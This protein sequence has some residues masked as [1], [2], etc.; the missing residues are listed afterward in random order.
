MVNGDRRLAK[1]NATD[2]NNNNNTNK[3]KIKVKKNKVKT[4]SKSN[5]QRGID[6]TKQ[7]INNKK[8]KVRKRVKKNTDITPKVAKI[9]KLMLVSIVHYLTMHIDQLTAQHI[10]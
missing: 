6:N 7:D 4:K 9:L 5:A 1:T 2:N 10:Y 3:V 8:Y